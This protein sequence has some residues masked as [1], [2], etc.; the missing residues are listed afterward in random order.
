MEHIHD[1]GLSFREKQDFDFFDASS[2]PASKGKKKVPVPLTWLPHAKY[3]FSNPTL[4]TL[5]LC[6]A[7]PHGGSIL[8]LFGRFGPLLLCFSFFTALLTVYAFV[9]QAGRI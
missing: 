3:V 9:L 4:S 2:I 5:G 8:H 1:R 6:T 7:A